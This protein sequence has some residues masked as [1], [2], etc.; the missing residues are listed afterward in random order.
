VS[1]RK[2]LDVALGILTG[3]ALGVA[4]AVLR[5][6]S[7]TSVKRVED[8]VRVCGVPNLAVVPYDS[9]AAKSPLVTQAR[10]QT[11]RAEAFRTLRTNLQFVDLDQPPRSVVVTSAVAGEGKSTS[12]CNLAITLAQAG[13]R[14]ALVEGD[15]RRPRVA[16]YMGVEP[17]VGLTS[18]LIGRATLAQAL[19][20]WA[21]PRL[22]VLAS[23]PIP[24]NPAELLGSGHMIA[25]LREL[26]SQADVV[27]VDAPP[28]LP[29]TDAAVLSR[30]TDGAVLVVRAGRTKRDQLASAVSALRTVDARLLGTVLNMV[31][32]KGPDGMGYGY[33]YGY[34]TRWPPAA[35]RPR[36]PSPRRRRAAGSGTSTAPRGRPPRR[37][38]RCRR[39]GRLPTRGGARRPARPRWRRPPRRRH[40][41]CP[42]ACGG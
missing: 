14:V 23:G 17:S 3:L 40:P 24:P 31:P 6:L 8:T 36:S 39:A 15:L 12:A 18:V 13:I 4:L 27:V 34:D 5:E 22:A 20:P 41:P 42:A 2:H 7:D 38:R 35:E 29:V 33:G 21:D 32:A 30:V 25:L 37:R 28:L 26:Q 16:D 10:N 9:A 19:Q 11:A 1:P